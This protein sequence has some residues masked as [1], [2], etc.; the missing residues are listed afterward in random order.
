MQALS[1]VFGDRIISRDIWPVCSS[2][3]NPCDFFFWGYFKD[4]VCSNNPRTEE[5][6][7]ENIRREISNIP[8]V[9]LQKVTQN[10]FRRCEECL[11]VE[12]QHFQHLLWSMNKGKDFPSFQMLIGM[13]SHRPYSHALRSKER[14]GTREAQCR[15]RVEL[16]KNHPVYICVI[17][18]DEEGR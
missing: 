6:L 2:D 12:G 1:D 14:S 18:R 9:H 11:R 15:K 16:I 8:A 13:L 4:K 17:G 10:L 7:K 5:E 3:L